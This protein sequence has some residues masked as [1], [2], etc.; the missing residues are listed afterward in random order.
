MRRRFAFSRFALYNSLLWGCGLLLLMSVP[1]Q[2]AVF[3]TTLDNGLTVLIEEQ[4]ATPAVSVQ[5][6]VRTG[7][8]YEQEYLGSGIS[9]FF[10]HILHG[11]STTAR[12]AEASRLLLESIGNNTNAY[13]TVDHTAYYITTSAEHWRTALDLLA[14]WL[15]HNQIAADEFEREKGVVQRELEQGLDNAEDILAQLVMETRYKVHPA[16]YPVIGYKALAQHITRHDLLTYYQRMYTPNNMILVLVGHLHT[17]TVLEEVR[18]TFGQA[19]Y[20]PLPSIVLP[21]EPRQVGKRLAVKEMPVS[22]AA[23]SLSFRTITVTHEHLYALDV[24]AY[25]LA[26]GNSSRLVQRVQE[27]Q[28]RVY[29]IRTASY[30]PAYTEGA[31]SVIATLEPGQIDTASEAILQEL[32][33]LREEFVTPAE[34]ARAQKQKMTDYLFT[35]QNVE[36]RARVLGLDMLST[37]DPQFSET[38]LTSIQ[39]VSAEDIREVA[40]RYFRADNL[41]QAVVR[42]PATT[43]PA[44]PVQTNL[45]IEPAVKK[46]LANGLTLLLQR[47]P[48][49]PTVAIHTAFQAGVRAETSDTNGISQL[50][51]AML[52]KGTPTRSAADIATLF[53]S[54]AASLSADAGHHSIVVQTTCLREDFR[55]LFDA[56]ADLLLHPTFPEAELHSARRALLAHI[57]RIA[58]DWHAEAE[59][60]WQETF[61]TVS[62]YRL[63]PNGS[64][65]VLQRLQRQDIVAFY[66]RYAVPSNMVMAIVGDIDMVATSQMVERLFAA[67]PPGPRPLLSVPFEPPPTQT[68]R[69]VRQTQKHLAA[70]F[71]GF[72]GTTLANLADRYPLYLLDG[73]LSGFDLPGGWL[74]HELRGQQLVYAVHA[75][76][77]LGLDAGYFGIYAGTRPDTVEHV[78]SI[79]LHNVEK[80]RTGQI[81]D[82][83]LTRMKQMALVVAR[84][85]RQTPEQFANDML[86]NELYGLGYDFSAQEEAYLMQVTKADVQRVAQTYLQHP[87]IVI[88]TPAPQ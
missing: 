61:F 3:H 8:L 66:Q 75:F 47:Q 40:R 49:W 72:P 80:A 21:A 15:L 16:R 7:S 25:I 73:I 19:P 37:Y 31:L 64:P 27:Q 34:L 13:T 70:V 74:H 86:F 23:L 46:V 20:R 62:P 28:Q 88:T 9:H 44:T 14:D 39:R 42:P 84:L 24:L 2:A 53:D 35:R 36:Q 67:L 38:Y 11:G 82:A 68:Q 76:N 57:E 54:K 17:A 12:S 22:Q 4:H 26:N 69:T 83:E 65:V 81:S 41:I 60:L 32:Y 56:Y 6:F 78:I 10:E 29:D 52:V 18:K 43:S 55:E 33:R 71:M 30:T 87:T 59:R 77:W 79:I 48:H 50:T 51:A 58:D 45:A 5:V 1:N 63:S 85:R